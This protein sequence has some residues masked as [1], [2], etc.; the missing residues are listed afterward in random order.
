MGAA[1]TNLPVAVRHTEVRPWG[2][3]IVIGG[4]CAYPM[5]AL[6]KEVFSREQAGRPVESA[7][8][9]HL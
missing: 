2:Q 8:R 9:N 7:I 1:L 4:L 6:N 3:N 5:R